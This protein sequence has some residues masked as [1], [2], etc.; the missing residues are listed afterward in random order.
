[1]SLGW[2]RRQ[3]NSPAST[4]GDN[5]YEDLIEQ[6]VF[7]VV[8][9]R[10][11]RSIVLVNAAFCRITGYTAEELLQMETTNRLLK[12]EDTVASDSVET[13]K[14]GESM[15]M[16]TELRRKDGSFVPIEATTLRLLNGNLQST[17]QD[18]TDRRRAEKARA[19]SEQRY[20][21]LVE[22]ALEG[23]LVRRHSGEFLYVNPAFC[24]MLGYSRG[25][26]LGMSIRDV[27]HTEDAATIEQVQRLTP[28]ESARTEKR[29]RHKDGHVVHVEVSAHRL[30]N[31]DVQSTVQDVSE[32]RRAE[33]RFRT[34][35]EG[36]PNAMLMVS[37]RGLIVLANPQTERLFGYRGEELLGQSI[38]ML[39]P[40]S[41]RDR[42]PRLRADYQR[43]PQMRSM[44]A[45][46]DLHGLR[47]DGTEVPVEIGLNP[48]ETP[49]GRF[50]LA[51]I[52]DISERK[53]AEA[54]DREHQEEMRVMSQRLL[55]AQETERR[56]IARE[57]HDEVGQA[58]TA[59]RLNLQQLVQEAGQGGLS[60]R[61][62]EASA[63]VAQLL[64]QV[65]QLSLDLHPSV[66]DDLG[67]AAALNWVVRTRAGGD[68]QVHLELAEGLPRFAEVTEHTAFRVCQEAL[69]NVLRHSG[70]RKVTVILRYAG[71]SLELVISDDG[72]GFE[73][74][75]AYKHAHE[76]KS[77]GVLGM[78]ERVRLAGGR[79]AIESN[80]GKGTH[81]QVWLP[82]M[83]R[84][85]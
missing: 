30:P 28:G 53:A 71:D 11:D 1:M 78:R 4:R 60:K 77:L 73:P 55:E 31:G 2:L 7:G 69:S 62:E 16:E 27:V 9:R 81:V 82:A 22:Q 43:E 63:M 44:G 8:V 42:H 23:I 26:L 47:K 79:I 10:P 32:S 64:Q 14:P 36:S 13:L 65:R 57:L 34:M 39:V 76:G 3:F 29:M 41:S 49:G 33:E 54:R 17:L 5:R 74:D 37:E 38:E 20:Q 15:Q 59:T 12:P 40:R 25:A 48:I 75:A 24:R 19:E 52:I 56:A 72:C 18:I 50:V 61:A 67:L 85:P 51:S 84:A 80:L 70:A 21:D 35:V 6:A 58:L 46:R 83:R 66:L 45:G 68:I